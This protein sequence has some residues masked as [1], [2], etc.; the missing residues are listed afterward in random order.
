MG[1]GHN[2]A[3]SAGGYRYSGKS[4]SYS[5]VYVYRA[6]VSKLPLRYSARRKIGAKRYSSPMFDTEREA[7]MWLDKALIKDGHEPINILKRK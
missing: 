2:W 1:T 7:A 3:A 5:Q 4:K 6:T